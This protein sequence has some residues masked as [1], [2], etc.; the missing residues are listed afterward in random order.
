MDLIRSL[1]NKLTLYLVNPSDVCPLSASH[2]LGTGGKVIADSLSQAS[3]I[4]FWILKQ[5][6][7]HMM[8]QLFFLFL[9]KEITNRL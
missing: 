5:N 7:I 1:I 4:L 2:E 6:S 3:Q 8:F 9:F